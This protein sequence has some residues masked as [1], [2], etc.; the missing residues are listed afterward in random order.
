MEESDPTPRF[1]KDT[2]A[3]FIDENMAAPVEIIDLTSS[4]EQRGQPVRYEIIKGNEGRIWCCKIS[5]GSINYYCS[6]LGVVHCKTKITWNNLI[7]QLKII[8]NVFL[9]VKDC[10]IEQVSE[11]CC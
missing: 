9:S 7:S 6:L 8:V 10:C 2:Y 3:G 1:A 11:C 4:D 5:T